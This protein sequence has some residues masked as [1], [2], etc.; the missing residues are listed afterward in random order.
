MYNMHM[1]LYI[2]DHCTDFDI[3]YG[4][5]KWDTEDLG[6]FFM[7]LRNLILRGDQIVTFTYYQR[8]KIKFL[9]NY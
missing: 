5:F 7:L 2:L 4:F 8:S 6:A 3:F 1:G 9:R